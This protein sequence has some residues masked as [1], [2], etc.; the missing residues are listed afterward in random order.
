[1]RQD[2]Y[3]EPASKKADSAKESLSKSFVKEGLCEEP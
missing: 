1:M 2:E 3:A